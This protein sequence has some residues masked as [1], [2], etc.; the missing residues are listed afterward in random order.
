M[1]K[2]GNVTRRRTDGRMDISTH[3]IRSFW[4]NDLKCRNAFTSEHVRPISSLVPHEQ[5]RLPCRPWSVPYAG[6]HAPPTPPG[7]PMGN[8]PGEAGA[9]AD[10]PVAVAVSG[11]RGSLDRRRRGEGCSRRDCTV[12]PACAAATS[13]IAVVLAVAAAAV[14]AVLVVLECVFVVVLAAATF[15]IVLGF[16][17]ETLFN[18]SFEQKL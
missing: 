7:R 11:L 15:R 16:C 4:R 5:F 2:T 17:N 1:E 10:A 3:F 18:L 9:D 13:A 12:P 14:A 6:S 8:G